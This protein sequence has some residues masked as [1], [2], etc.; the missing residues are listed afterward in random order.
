MSVLRADAPFFWPLRGS[1]ALQ[2]GSGSPTFTRASAAWGF[3]ELGKM[4]KVPSGAIRMRGYR[5]V[6]NWFVSPDDIAGSASWSVSNV[7]KASAIG[8]DGVSSDA[9]LNSW[10]SYSA[11]YYCVKGSCRSH[12]S[13]PINHPGFCINCGSSQSQI[14]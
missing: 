2:N 1:L 4:Y 6:V 11:M 14:Y 3:N 5:P 13:K 9:I 8:P 12:Q 10:D 7:S